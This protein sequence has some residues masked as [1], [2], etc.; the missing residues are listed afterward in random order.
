LSIIFAGTDPARFATALTLAATQAALGGRVR[1]LLDGAAVAMANQG[2]DLLAT[3]FELGVTVTL[4]Q[5]G[6][7]TA[8]LAADTL[9]RRFDYGGMASFLA[10][11]GE[12]RL[13]MA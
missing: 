3:C 5:S 8:G 2:G 12:D 9:D 6:L 10:E 11:L 4:C 1:L 13:L 7:A